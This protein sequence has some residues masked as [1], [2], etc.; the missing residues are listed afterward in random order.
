M[1]IGKYEYHVLKVHAV[2]D[3]YFGN[4]VGTLWWFDN[5]AV[6]ILST[7]HTFELLQEWL[8]KQPGKKS[9][10]AKKVQEVFGD[11]QG[12]EMTIPLCIDDYNH[13]M[14]G[15]DIADQ[16]HSYNDTQITSLHTLWPML[17]WTNFNLIECIVHKSQIHLVKC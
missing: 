5:I 7:V 10:N 14:G 15:M 8:R 2:K 13:N 9:T 12:K 11:L 1:D 6:T 16:R 4:L 17:L 3:S